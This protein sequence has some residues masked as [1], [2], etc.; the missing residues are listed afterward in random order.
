MDVQTVDVFAQGKNDGGTI[1]SFGVVHDVGDGQTVDVKLQPLND[2][3]YVTVDSLSNEQATIFR[4]E[5]LPAFQ[6][7]TPLLDSKSVP[8]QLIYEAVIQWKTP[9]AG[10]WIAVDLS[11]D[12]FQWV[13]LVEP[14]LGTVRPF[15][16]PNPLPKLEP[17]NYR[18]RFD[19]NWNDAFKS[20]DE[21]FA[22]SLTGWSG[23]EERASYT[24]GKVE[25]Y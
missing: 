23:A 13:F 22:G 1:V 5:L 20:L 17:G 6:L 2:I 3:A 15:A 4:I 24:E 14:S 7:I 21:L 19:A 9:A 10:Q 25:F 18:L 11:N 8:R 12:K 16:M